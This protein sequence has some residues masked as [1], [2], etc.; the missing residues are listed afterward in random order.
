[1]NSISSKLSPKELAILRTGK[2][3]TKNKSVDQEKDNR[4]NSRNFQHTHIQTHT[5]TTMRRINGIIQEYFLFLKTHT[6]EFVVISSYFHREMKCPKFS[7]CLED[8]Q[9]EFL[10]K[11]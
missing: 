11:T 9:Y 5:S 3:D 6:Q 2:A 1:M 4:Y 10:T 8:T 7:H